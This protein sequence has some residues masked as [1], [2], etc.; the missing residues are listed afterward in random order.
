MTNDEPQAGEPVEHAGGD[1]AQDMHSGFHREP[2][3]RS[4]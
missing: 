1:H 2:V 4:V 3:D